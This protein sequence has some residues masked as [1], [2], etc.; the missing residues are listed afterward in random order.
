MNILML[1]PIKPANRDGCSIHRMELIR[2]FCNLHHHVHILV[3]GKNNESFKE[4]LNDPFIHVK[5][6]SS[7]KFVKTF[8]YIYNIFLFSIYEKSSILYTRNAIYCGFGIIFKSINK[9]ILI[10][11]KNGIISDE[12]DLFSDF[13]KSSDLNKS[14]HRT[15]SHTFL[16]FMEL[17]FI[18]YCDAVVAVTPLIKKY[19]IE[20]NID[21]SKIHVIEN[22]AN[23]DLFKPFDKQT[24]QREMGLDQACQYVCFV[25]NFAPWQGLEYLIQAAPLVLKKISAKFLIVGDGIVREQL[26]KMVTELGMD[27]SFI[28]TGLVLYEDVPKYINASDVCVAPFVKAR[29][30]KI[31][32]SP[33]KLYEYLACGKSVVASNI[34]GVGD[35]LENSNSGISVAPDDPNELAENIIKLLTDIQLREQMGNNGR[36]L[37]VNNYSWETTSKKT[38]EVFES[39]LDK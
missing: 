15:K 11:E 4:I 31:G 1:D 23:T 35:I 38:I 9:S 16:E 39:I 5:Y 10:F 25:G 30:E 12:S 13:H 22:G 17:F 36:K 37:A 2:N 7:L 26:E 27:D 8:Q 28:F 6:V 34:K 19:L 24:V 33:L 21:E 29:N 14:V 3:N 32:L 18:K 20:K